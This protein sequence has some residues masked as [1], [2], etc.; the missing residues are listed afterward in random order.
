MCTSKKHTGIKIFDRPDMEGLVF[1]ASPTYPGEQNFYGVGEIQDSAT[2]DCYTHLKM[3][4]SILDLKTTKKCVSLWVSRAS[5]VS[6]RSLGQYTQWNH[7]PCILS[8]QRSQIALS[9]LSCFKYAMERVLTENM[10]KQRA[11]HTP[12]IILTND[13]H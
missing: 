7:S 2:Q 9:C 4:I 11:G 5:H 12:R 3:F 6:H 8:I 13:M 10:S 1:A